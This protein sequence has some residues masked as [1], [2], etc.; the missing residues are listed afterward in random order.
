M[1][2]AVTDIRI[3][4]EHSLAVVLRFLLRRS[5]A[6]VVTPL[7]DDRWEVTV[8]EEDSAEVLK[9]AHDNRF[10]QSCADRSLPCS[11]ARQ[12]PFT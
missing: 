4:G 1:T 10:M 9:F 12:Y 3:Q 8:K 5:L 11:D 7:P 2:K 6:F